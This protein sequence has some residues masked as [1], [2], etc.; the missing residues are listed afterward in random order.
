MTIEKR[1]YE[2]M[3]EDILALL[4]E[5]AAVYT[6]SGGSQ[7]TVVIYGGASTV[8]RHD[9]RKTA[10][11]IDYT[12]REPVN[13]ASAKLF[14]ECVTAVGNRHRFPP[15]WMHGMPYLWEEPCYQKN[16]R[17]H[18]ELLTGWPARKAGAVTFLIQDDEW[19]LAE[20]LCYFRRQKR[21]AENILGFL[22][23][24]RARGRF[25]TRENIRQF[26][27]NVYDGKKQCSWEG[28]ALLRL[29]GPETDLASLRNWHQRRAAY[30]RK[31]Y[32]Y[33]DWVIFPRCSRN[34]DACRICRY[35][36]MAWETKA[37]MLRTFEVYD[38]SVPD[39]ITT[40]LA[41]HFFDSKYTAMSENADASVG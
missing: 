11:D 26:V 12:F 4:S 32:G 16:L 41:R 18:T 37:D 9:F 36:C 15:K 13:P 6:E 30:Y 33:L 19:F 38:V 40:H 5:V 28:E 14:A 17:R 35:E 27:L 29:L 7:L 22:Q 10:H 39:P 31:L 1:E 8:L 2:L 25:L 21:D 23:E 34:Y 20:S 24:E 3:R